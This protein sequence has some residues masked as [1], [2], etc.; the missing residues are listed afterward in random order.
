MRRNSQHFTVFGGAYVSEMREAS[1]QP[2]RGSGPLT[3]VAVA[4]VFGLAIT[5]AAGAA[6]HR[7]RAGSWEPHLTASYDPAKLF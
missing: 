6:N 7:V 1:I 4:F 5:V 3:A 2:R